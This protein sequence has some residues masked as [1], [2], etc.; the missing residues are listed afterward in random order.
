MRTALYVKMCEITEFG[1]RVFSP[2]TAPDNTTKPYCIVKMLGDDP[3]VNNRFGT[4]RSFSVFIYNSPDSFIPLDSLVALVRT[5]LNNV[6]IT[7]A[8]GD[9]FICEYIKTLQDYK[10]ENGD[11]MI[12]VD[13][14]IPGA[15][16]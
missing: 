9:N 5:K 7:T 2:Y 14:D 6:T 3:V 4:I 15:R 1:N 8:D 16:P 12:R 13:F 10:T 11:F